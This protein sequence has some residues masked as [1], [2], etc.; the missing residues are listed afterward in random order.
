MRGLLAR[1]RAHHDYWT[2]R[3]QVQCLWQIRPDR[4]LASLGPESARI[5]PFGRYG[6][7][8]LEVTLVT[9]TRPGGDRA[10]RNAHRHRDRGRRADAVAHLG[11]DQGASDRRRGRE[12]AEQ[13][14]ARTSA[15]LGVRL[16]GLRRR[17][18]GVRRVGFAPGWVRSRSPAVDESDRR[19]GS[20]RRDGLRSAAPT[21]AHRSRGKAVGQDRASGVSGDRCD[22]SA[23]QHR[24]AVA[25]SRSTW[26]S[27][28]TPASGSPRWPAGPRIDRAPAMDGVLH[29]SRLLRCRGST[30]I[31]PPIRQGRGAVAILCQ[32][33]P[34][35]SAGPARG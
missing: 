14:A 13:P 7:G 34:E 27:L 9:T 35:V 26:A 29:D 20:S 3:S 1:M 22:A 2:T 12:R 6:I 16:G 23:R 30:R 10:R 24:A 19:R 25:C 8:R 18:Q 5:R 21:G 15:Q 28:L 32:P 4:A 11:L 33:S 31:V 17:I